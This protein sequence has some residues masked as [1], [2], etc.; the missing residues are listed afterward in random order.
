MYVQI[1]SN[2]HHHNNVFNVYNMNN[3]KSFANISD[4]SALENLNK[5]PNKIT[6]KKRKIISG[7]L[8]SFLNM[9]LSVTCL[10]III[11]LLFLIHVK[12]MSAKSIL[13]LC[14]IYASIINTSFL[15]VHCVLFCY[16]ICWLCF[17]YY[18]YFIMY[19]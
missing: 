19:I 4:L 16:G 5:K 14:Q 8:Q 12:D 1:L 7:K 15:C 13:H 9:V 2:N 6:K 18:F 3:S 17:Y 10:L 11:P